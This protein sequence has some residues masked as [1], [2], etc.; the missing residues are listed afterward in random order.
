M[1]TNSDGSISLLHLVFL[2]F[3]IFLGAIFFFEQNNDQNYGIE[4]ESSERKKYESDALV[5]A[6]SHSVLVED[7]Y[8]NKIVHYQRYKSETLS[9]IAIAIGALVGAPDREN[10]DPLTTINFG[11]N[12][13]LAYLKPHQYRTII[14]KFKVLSACPVDF[15]NENNHQVVQMIT[16]EDSLSEKI[17]NLTIQSG[18]KFSLQGSPLEVN[19]IEIN[20]IKAQMKLGLPDNWEFFLIES[21]AINGKIL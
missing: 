18:D 10:A 7:A 20:G 15:L 13:I 11:V 4:P 9:G 6:Y 19:Q 16:E 21:I 8:E 12:K 1:I 14:D 17:H 5:Y 2:V 3:F